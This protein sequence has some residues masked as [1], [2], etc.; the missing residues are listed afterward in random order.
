MDADKQERLMAE[1]EILKGDLKR[2]GVQLVFSKLIKAAETLPEKHIREY[3]ESKKARIQA[4]Y[5]V[6][7]DEIPRIMETI[8]NADFE[9]LKVKNP[10][11]RKWAFW[12]WIK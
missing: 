5:E 12:E 8:M 2:P 10:S 9:L 7:H 3:D 1:K 6:L 4:L 11:A